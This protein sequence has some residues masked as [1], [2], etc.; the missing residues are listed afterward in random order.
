MRI[1]CARTALPLN[2]DELDDKCWAEP[3]EGESG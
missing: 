2:L 1:G 3:S